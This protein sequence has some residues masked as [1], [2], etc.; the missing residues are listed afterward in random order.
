M[1]IRRLKGPRRRHFKT[2]LKEFTASVR[3]A[4][5][6]LGILKLLKKQTFQESAEKGFFCSELVAAAWQ[7][8]RVIK[9]E[10]APNQFWP[11]DFADGGVIEK[12][13]MAGWTMEPTV[14][15]DTRVLEV[16]RSQVRGAAET[17]T[18]ADDVIEIDI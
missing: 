5:Y 18:A 10:R 16:G 9:T 4:K 8:T 14:L 11:T 17:V 6:N 15:I 2:S 13:L 3:G 7:A 1:A 12:S